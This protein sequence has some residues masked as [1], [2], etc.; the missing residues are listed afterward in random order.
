MTFREYIYKTIAD[1]LSNVAKGLFVYSE[2]VGY[3][4]NAILEKPLVVSAHCKDGDY[5]YPVKKTGLSKIKV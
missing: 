1:S 3:G 4:S 2:S 5:I